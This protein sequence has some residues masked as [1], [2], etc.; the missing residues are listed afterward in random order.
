LSQR[1]S[2]AIACGIPG[3]ATAP[4]AL[5]WPRVQLET[6][7]PPVLERK[8]PPSCPVRLVCA[9]LPSL[10][11][12]PLLTQKYLKIGTT[13]CHCKTSSD[14]RSPIYASPSPT[15]VITV[16]STVAPATKEPNTRT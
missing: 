13:Q 16:A 6:V 12:N 14:E 2:I 1:F 10:I 5:V 4:D 7:V 3:L 8:P 15:G 11:S 9:S